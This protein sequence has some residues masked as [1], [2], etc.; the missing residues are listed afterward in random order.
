MY[1]MRRN[2]T[3]PSVEPGGA[4]QRPLAGVRV[5]E[6]GSFVA[7][8]AA[9]RI[10]AD[11]GAEVIKVESP[12][13]GDELRQCGELIETRDGGSVSAWWLSQARN[14]RFVT[15]NLRVEEGQ[16]LVLDLIAKSD[17]VV[18]NFRPGRLEAW[19]LSYD[20]MCERN[21]RIVLVR[22]SGYGQTGPYREKAGYGNVSESMGG[23]RYVTG[24]PD[25]PP[26]RVGVSLGDSLA[27]QQAVIGALLA[28]RVAEQTGKGQVVDVAITEAVFAVTEGMV[29]EYAHKGI[30]RKR[31]G[32]KLLRA[33]PS[34]V[35]ST[36]DDKW[37]AIGGNG[38]NVFRRF[39]A[40]MGMP[41]LA[42][43]PRFKDNRARVANHDALDDI[44][45]RWTGERTLT[46]IQRV[47]DV[48]GV[49]AGPVVSIADI[50]ADPQFQARDML[51]RVPDERLPEG[52]AILPGIVPRLTATPGRVAHTGGELG[53]DNDAILG[54]LLGLDA[55]ERNRLAAHGVIGAHH[56]VRPSISP[57][58]EL[59]SEMRG[60]E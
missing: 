42:T 14:K 32:N 43:D 48:A 41:E 7:A 30:V 46:D 45:G 55:D 12:D 57:D 20:R 3:E 11:F 27:A 22:I 21:P 37:I 44:I 40:A 34:N 47:L 50:A 51:A 8:P 13:T 18:E 52:A 39:C 58:D 17:I 49:P 16:K 53:A 19:N 56:A 60:A 26:V 38:E 25:R 23:L 24:F 15:L 54:D 2:P 9:T 5:I 31:A 28:F 6:L 35:Y 36:A 4:S 33:A 10:L 59:R 29:T 1:A